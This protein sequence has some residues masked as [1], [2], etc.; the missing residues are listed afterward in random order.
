[1]MVS[2]R[3]SCEEDEESSFNNDDDDNNDDNEEISEKNDVTVKRHVSV[4]NPC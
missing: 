2:E 3:V 4:E 1:M